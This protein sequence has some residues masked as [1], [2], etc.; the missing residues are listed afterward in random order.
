MQGFA[1]QLGGFSDRSHELFY[2]L[3]VRCGKKKR[4][5]AGRLAKVQELVDVQRHLVLLSQKASTKQGV[6]EVVGD[7]EPETSILIGISDLV[8]HLPFFL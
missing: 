1:R 7:L 6:C 8:S 3:R 4:N 5:L 2:A